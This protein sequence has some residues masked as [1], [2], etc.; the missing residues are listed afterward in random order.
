[1]LLEVFD[2]VTFAQFIQIACQALAV[3]SSIIRA[4]NPSYIRGAKLLFFDLSRISPCHFRDM[5]PIFY[6]LSATQL[7]IEQPGDSTQATDQLGGTG[8]QTCVY[9][10][11]GGK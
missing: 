7:F 6:I 2:G 8:Q 3:L 9:V 10:R 4:N 11:Q 1:M 5:K